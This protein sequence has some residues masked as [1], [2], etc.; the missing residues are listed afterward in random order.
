LPPLEETTRRLK[1]AREEIFGPMVA[2]LKADDE[3]DALDRAKG[4]GCFNGAWD[5]EEVRRTR[6]AG[7]S[8]SVG[9]AAFE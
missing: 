4:L 3:A 1:I 7:R 6:R 2:I 9:A 8:C 5:I